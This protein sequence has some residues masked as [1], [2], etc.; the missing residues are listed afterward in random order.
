M[1]SIEL[2]RADDGEHKDGSVSQE[3]AGPTHTIYTN[4]TRYFGPNQGARGNGAERGADIRRIVAAL[5]P[6]V[7]SEVRSL[8]ARLHTRPCGTRV[9]SVARA[10]LLTNTRP[11]TL[12]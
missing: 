3:R 8:P 2:T 12:R 4:A 1:E 7:W 6:V 10:A 5:P 11:Y 9:V